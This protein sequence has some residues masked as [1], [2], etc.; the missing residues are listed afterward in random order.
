M[1]TLEKAEQFARL[2]VKGAPVLL[3]NA[4]DAGSAKAIAG[5][6]AKAVATSS[7]AVAAAQGHTDG[8][9]TPVELVHAIVGRIVT[10]VD[11]PVSVDFEGGYSE[12]EAG[13]AENITRLLKLGVVGINFEDRVVRGEGLYT[14]D[15]Q[16]SRIR[17]IRTAADQAGVPLFI[18]ARTDLFLG[19]GAPDPADS[20]VEATER[21]AAYA[22]AGASS[23]FI[24]GLIDAKLIARICE[25]VSLPVNVMMMTGAPTVHDLAALGAARISWGTAPYVQTMAALGAAAAQVLR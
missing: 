8:E 4:W 21:A 23:F 22:A 6:G 15:R 25:A 3:Y 12:D 2:H 24:P 7:W 19:R 13:L 11:L 9:D 17:A 16:A 10:A 1:T 20:I 5:A 18:N 14:V